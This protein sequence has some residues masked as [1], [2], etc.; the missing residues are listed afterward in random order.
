MKGRNAYEL[1][2]LRENN[3]S[4]YKIVSACSPISADK[5]LQIPQEENKDV[6]IKIYRK[7]KNN[8]RSRI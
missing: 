1:Q 8:I 3:L 7:E 2:T 5:L 6:L 4:F